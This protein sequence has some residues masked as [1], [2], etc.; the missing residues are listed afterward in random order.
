[1]VGR[2][3][4]TPPDFARLAQDRGVPNLSTSWRNART[5]RRQIRRLAASHAPGYQLPMAQ[6]ADAQIEIF[7]LSDGTGETG[8]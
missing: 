3:C 8:T 2:S 4:Q 5:P 1:M 6:G 7:L